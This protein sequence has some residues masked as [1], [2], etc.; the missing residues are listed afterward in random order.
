MRVFLLYNFNKFGKETR[1]HK[2]QAMIHLKTMENKKFVDLEPEQI[3][4]GEGSFN[5]YTNTIKILDNY[6][7]DF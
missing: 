2:V 7:K 6:R 1:S 3:E 4:F 5:V